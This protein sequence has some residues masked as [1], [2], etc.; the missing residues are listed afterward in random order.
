MIRPIKKARHQILRH[1]VL[2]EQMAHTTTQIEFHKN[3]M[4]TR[5]TRLGP[6]FCAASF[7]SRILRH[8]LV[9]KD[10]L[11]PLTFNVPILQSSIGLSESA[12]SRITTTVP[13]FF[14]QAFI[15]HASILF[16]VASLFLIGSHSLPQPVNLDATS[17]IKERQAHYQTLVL[18]FHLSVFII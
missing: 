9:D 6:T 1:V 14:L 15:M 10:S 7:L 12:P 4:M 17:S 3:S 11:I 13:P 18:Q 16:P 2:D 8:S 5:C